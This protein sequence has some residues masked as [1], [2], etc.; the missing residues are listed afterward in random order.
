MSNEASNTTSQ[1]RGSPVL[2]EITFTSPSPS[3][4]SSNSTEFMQIEPLD[5]GTKL[6]VPRWSHYLGSDDDSDIDEDMDMDEDM[7]DSIAASSDTDTSDVL[8]STDLTDGL[9][10]PDRDLYLGATVDSDSDDS[11]VVEL[12][13]D[14]TGTWDTDD[15]NTTLDKDF[16]CA[17]SSD[18][19]TSDLVCSTDLTDGLW[20]PDRDL[21]LGATVD[22]DS[23]DSSVIEL[24]EEWDTD[25]GNTTLDK[26]FVCATDLT[27]GLWDPDR[28]FYQGELYDHMVR[29][30]QSAPN[31]TIISSAPVRCPNMTWDPTR[32]LHRRILQARNPVD[33]TDMEKEMMD[34][35]PGQ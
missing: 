24:T 23:D 31:A 25:D 15:G 3:S 5:H 11:S 16:V 29:V 19:D 9:W 7:D 34:D 28:N 1:E 13:E 2:P 32:I 33:M 8:F 14:P 18:T 10:D 26:D 4:S 17:T 35:V 30:L 22:S 12:T 21:Y 6:T 20:D 27:D